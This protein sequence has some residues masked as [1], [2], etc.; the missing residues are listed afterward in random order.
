MKMF[1]PEVDKPHL[2]FPK[3]ANSIKAAECRALVPI[4]AALCEEY[5]IPGD[6]EWRTR[7]L[8][9][10]NLNR[11]YVRMHI[12]SVFPS[13]DDRAKMRT[14]VTSC[15]ALYSSMARSAA[16]AGL[17]KWSIVNKFHFWYHCGVDDTWINPRMLWTYQGEDYQRHVK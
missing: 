9:I 3:L 7:T 15:L 17:K 12:A 14:A 5:D 13:L 4:V 1:L 8:C 2:H 16:D 11:F 6:V 10:R